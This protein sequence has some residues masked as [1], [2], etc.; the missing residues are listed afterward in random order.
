M[1]EVDVQHLQVG[2]HALRNAVMPGHARLRLAITARSRHLQPA[3]LLS[4][5]VLVPPAL[6]RFELLNLCSRRTRTR[7]RSAR[8]AVGLSRAQIEARRLAGIL[9]AALLLS[10]PLGPDLADILIGVVSSGRRGRA[11]HRFDNGAI[12]LRVWQDSA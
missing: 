11:V 8:L 3:E 6:G 1:N 2:S 7:M 10:R 5:V 4:L 12:L 9:L